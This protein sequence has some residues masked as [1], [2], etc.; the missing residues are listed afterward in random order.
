MLL[1]WLGV[2]KHAPVNVRIPNRSV[3]CVSNNLLIL[4]T[5]IPSDFSRKCR[6]LNEISRFNATEYSELYGPQFVSHNVHGLLHIVDDYRKFKSLEECSCF[7]FENYMKVLKKMVR[8]HEKPFEQ[9]IKRNQESLLFNKP[10]LLKPHSNGPS[11]FEHLTVPNF[12]ISTSDSYIG[13]TDETGLKIF[14]VFNICLDSTTEKY[15]KIKMSQCLV[16]EFEDNSIEAVP[17]DSLFKARKMVKKG[18]KNIDISSTDDDILLKPKKR[19][20]KTASNLQF[21]SSCPTFSVSEDNNCS[22]DE[23]IKKK[24]TS[25]TLLNGWSPSPKKVKLYEGP[26]NPPTSLT[27]ESY[28]NASKSSTVKKL[29]FSDDNNTSLNGTLKYK[30]IEFIN[31]CGLNVD[32]TN[33]TCDFIDIN[34]AD[35]Y[36]FETPGNLRYNV[37]KSTDLELDKENSDVIVISGTPQYTIDPLTLTKTPENVTPILQIYVVIVR[38]TEFEKEVLHRLEIIEGI[39][40]NIPPHDISTLNNNLGDQSSLIDKDFNIPLDNIIDLEIFEDK[41]SDNKEFRTKLVNELSYIG[42]K[43]VKAMVKRVMGKLFKDQLL[44]DFSYTDTVKKQNK[45]KIHLKMKWRISSNMSL[46]KPLF[47]SSD[48]DLKYNVEE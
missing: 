34:S 15:C 32:Q 7:P 21:S 31:M 23:N 22:S 25:K 41:I 28:I 12:Q 1:I 24:G 39:L 6:G 20:T 26:K 11:E 2:L 35:N 33:L 8:K 19:T 44:K 29:S 46:L 36:V 27:K 10:V 47:T 40:E 14:K 5:F 48:D 16:V 30:S 13:F 37:I 18:L 4:N 17:A 42:G 38:T 43:H 3:N 9:V 45:F